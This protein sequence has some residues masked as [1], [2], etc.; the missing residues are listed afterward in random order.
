MDDRNG[1]LTKIMKVRSVVVEVVEEGLSLRLTATNAIQRPLRKG[2]SDELKGFIGI[3]APYEPPEDSR[4]RCAHAQALPAGIRGPDPRRAPPASAVEV[5]DAESQM[6]VVKQNAA[7][8]NGADRMTAP[9][10]T[11]LPGHY[12]P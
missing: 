1:I 10:F 5:I 7:T 2:R 3:D 4:N 8:L 12:R 11:T 9:L 6:N